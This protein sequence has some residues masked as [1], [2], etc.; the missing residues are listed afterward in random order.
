MQTNLMNLFT[1]I[2]WWNQHRP[3]AMLIPFG[4]SCFTE[5]GIALSSSVLKNK[6]KIKKAKPGNFEKF[7]FIIQEGL[8]EKRRCHQAILNHLAHSSFREVMIHNWKKP[9]HT[10]VNCFWHMCRPSHPRLHKYVSGKSVWVQLQVF[11]FLFMGCTWRNSCDLANV[12]CHAVLSDGKHMSTEVEK[13]PSH[14]PALTQ[15][16]YHEKGKSAADAVSS[17]SCVS[18]SSCQQWVACFS[19]F[20]ET[21]MSHPTRSAKKKSNFSF[22]GAFGSKNL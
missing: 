6:T 16:R 19:Y 20:P 13:K 10:G 4:W 9:K 1:T 14:S 2:T 22:Q 7:H 8:N 18:L 15:S 21:C 3:Y 11:S 12:R 17:P 5:N